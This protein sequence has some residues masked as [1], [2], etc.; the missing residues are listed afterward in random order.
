ME[1]TL[2]MRGR[3]FVLLAADG[4]AGR[5]IITYKHDEDR[6]MVRVLRAVVARSGRG[7]STRAR[8]LRRC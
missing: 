8:G 5:S 4:N 3:D 1:C 6:V 2:G 7:P